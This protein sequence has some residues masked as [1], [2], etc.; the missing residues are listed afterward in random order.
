M[1]LQDNA[2]LLFSRNQGETSLW[3]SVLTERYGRLQLTYKGGQKKAA[4]LLNFSPLS[5]SWRLGK[6][7]GGWIASCESFAYQSPLQGMANWSGL[8]TNELLHRALMADQPVPNLYQAYA[9]LMDGLRSSNHDRNH[10][11]WALRSFEWV[12]IAEMGYGLPTQTYDH[13]PLSAQ[14]CYQWQSEGWYPSETGIHGTEL[15][16]LIGQSKQGK[17][18]RALRELLQWRLLQAMPNQALS[19]RHWWEQLK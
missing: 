9:A 2:F 17:S 4:G 7:G 6:Q 16:A 14:A 11:A 10:M 18:S 1:L 5:L 13:K 8:Y 15:L 19:M 3:L 12:F